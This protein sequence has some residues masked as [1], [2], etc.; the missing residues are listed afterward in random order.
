MSSNKNENLHFEQPLRILKTVAEIWKSNKSTS[1]KNAADDARVASTQTE[2]PST[3]TSVSQTSLNLRNFNLPLPKVTQNVEVQTSGDIEQRKPT[4]TLDR[5]NLPDISPIKIM[6][7]GD[8]YK[9]DS[10][11]PFFHSNIRVVPT[12]KGL[13]PIRPKPSTVRT[14]GA[15]ESS[16]PPTSTESPNTQTTPTSVTETPG[17]ENNFQERLRRQDNAHST[18]SQLRE[19]DRKGKPKK[20]PQPQTDEEFLNDLDTDLKHLGNKIAATIPKNVDTKNISDIA[21]KYLDNDELFNDLLEVFKGFNPDTELESDDS[22]VNTPVTSPLP[23]QDLVDNHADGVDSDVEENNA[24]EIVEIPDAIEGD[25]AKAAA[26]N[27]KG[28]D[29]SLSTTNIEVP[30]VES[31]N[32][33]TLAQLVQDTINVVTEGYNVSPI[34]KRSKRK[35]TTVR[36]RTIKK[37]KKDS[38]ANVQSFQRQLKGILHQDQVNDT[39]QVNSKSETEQAASYLNGGDG[40]KKDGNTIFSKFALLCQENL[41][42]FKDDMDNDPVVSSVDNQLDAENNENCDVKSDQVVTENLVDYNVVHD[43]EMVVEVLEGKS[44]KSRRQRCKTCTACL[45]KPCGVCAPC[46][47]KVKNGGRGT[48]KKG[49]IAQNC[50]MLKTKPPKPTVEEV[51]HEINL[52]NIPAGGATIYAPPQ[53]KTPN[54]SSIQPAVKTRGLSKPQPYHVRNLG[55]TSSPPKEGPKVK[56]LSKFVPADAESQSPQ[57][58]L[59]PIK[60]TDSAWNKDVASIFSSD[61]KVGSQP[62]SHKDNVPEAPLAAPPNP[63]LVRKDM[64]ELNTPLT[65]N[66]SYPSLNAAAAPT[67]PAQSTVSSVKSATAPLPH[68]SNLVPIDAKC[69]PQNLQI[70]SLPPGFKTAGFGAVVTAPAPAGSLATAK[71]YRIKK[72]SPKGS[73]KSPKSRLKTQAWDEA[74]R[75]SLGSAEKD[76][77]HIKSRAAEEKR[78]RRSPKKIRP[79]SEEDKDE[80]EEVELGSEINLQDTDMTPEAQKILDTFAN[81]LLEQIE[82]KVAENVVHIQPKDAFKDKKLFGESAPSKGKKVEDKKKDKDCICCKVIFYLA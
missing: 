32:M 7:S 25:A 21:D 49:C 28:F 70:T 79:E 72:V 71:P 53:S 39:R 44:S 68:P 40:D 66:M 78:K 1:A 38:P 59:S 69:I 55:F 2:S 14:I 3:S 51:L 56:S 15:Q 60:R 6:R 77:S 10:K 43:D 75:A 31:N 29:A 62:S 4:C 47:D 63:Y 41:G 82:E 81:K 19:R 33:D 5:E 12:K 80:E 50:L 17:T 27:T 61:K 48:L 74:L 34:G 37:L 36:K 45:A 42:D 9:V 22:R 16:Q 64:A 23:D 67:A 26:D 8:K 65:I 11:V 52:E 76:V 13:M 57:K 30:E 58:N 18:P 54:K 35:K 73:K 24:M 46:K 20:N